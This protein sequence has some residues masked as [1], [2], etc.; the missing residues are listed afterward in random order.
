MK[1]LVTVMLLAVVVV[2]SCTKKKND[3]TITGD[4]MIIGR[5]GGFTTGGPTTYY[6]INNG[7]LRSDNTVSSAAPHNNV[8]SFKFN[9]LLSDAKYNEARRLPSLVPAE[10]LTRNGQRIGE[11]LIDAGYTDVRY[12]TGGVAYRWYI[13]GNQDSSSAEVQRFVDSLN[14]VFR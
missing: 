14:I 4:Y 2:S 6:L 8:S 9:T 11:V 12:S 7:Q 13:E 10:L 3:Y 5:A 1:H